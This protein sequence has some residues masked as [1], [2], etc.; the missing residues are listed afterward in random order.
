MGLLLTALAA[1]YL[2]GSFPTAYVL[3]KW[4]KRIDVRTVGSGNVGATNVTRVAGLRAGVAVFLI[5]AAKGAISGWAIPNGLFSAPTPVVQIGCGLLAV[6][7]HS[8]PIFLGFRGGKG[9]ATTIGALI[10]T[11]PVVAALCLGVWVVVFVWSRYV[12]VA[13]LATAVT[14]PIAQGLTRSG[15]WEVLLGVLWAGVIVVRHRG[16]MERLLAGTEHRAGP[17]GV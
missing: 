17:R 16:N 4:L 3:V 2:V 6:V 1:S 14:I 7:G 11:M 5:D 8:F 12:S 13:S 10:S 9:V 15:P